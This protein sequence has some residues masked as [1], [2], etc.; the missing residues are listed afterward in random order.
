YV[1]R[2]FNA[3]KPFDQFLR[4]QIAGDELDNAGYETR[5][6]TGFM[7]NYAKVGFREK[8]NPH[9]RFDYLD[10]MIATIG[11]GVLGL[12]LQC[13]RCHNHKYD[14]VSQ[15]DYY[16]LQTSLYGYVE[17]EHPLVPGEQ[18]AAHEAKIKDIESRLKPLQETVREIEAPYR[19]QIQKEKFKR[20]PANIQEAIETPEDQRT[21]GQVLLANQVIRTTGVSSGEIERLLPPELFARVRRIRTEIRAIEKERPAPIPTAMGIT[22]GDYRF[23]PDGPGDEPAPG[24]GVKR[25]VSEGSFLY[26]GSKPYEVPPSYFLHRGDINSRGSEMAPGF[27]AL[28]SASTT[29]VATPPASGRTSGRRRALAEWLV[30]RDNPLTARVFVNRV[31]HHHFGR[32]LVPSLDNF[33]KVGDRPTHPE[34]LDWLAVEFMENGW[35]VKKLHKLLMTSRAY[36][37]SSQYDHKASASKDP[38]NIYLWRFRQQRLEA[39][40]VRDMIL[41][42]AGSLNAAQFGPPVFPPV[43]PEI[44]QSMKNGIWHTGPDG[45][46]TWR[47]SVYVYRKRGLPFPLFEIFDLPDQNVSCGRRNVSTVPTQALA[48]LHNEFV[49]AHS[50]RFAARL[51]QLAPNDP[52]RQVELAYEIALSRPP[53][54]EE[55][56]LGVEFVGREG[57]AGLAHVMLNLNEFIYLR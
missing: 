26:D 20:Y 27:P 32:G 24:K 30:S 17:I 48:L 41:A 12:T 8:D 57:L 46:E 9:F 22:D 31:W 19:A 3:G 29:P 4:E 1:I 5:I 15:K 7:R 54:P 38:E 39:E 33:G 47:R 42:S 55:K 18:A 52:A 2:A 10:D 11:R 13:A 35:N 23:A 34:L 49:L 50:R 25:E 37:L 21:P 40:I 6:A 45:P 53:A 16:R 51:D 43:A 36:T 56:R 44:L 28:L 14:P